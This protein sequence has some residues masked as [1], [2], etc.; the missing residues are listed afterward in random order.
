M[1]LPCSYNGLLAALSAEELDGLQPQLRQAALHQGTVLCSEGQP[2]THVYFPTTA[3]ISIACSTITGDSMDVAIIADDGLAGLTF[4]A[5]GE[6]T[7]GRVVVQRS[8]EAWRLPASV[9]RQAFAQ[10]GN[11]QLLA[12][13]YQQFLMAQMAQTALCSRLHRVDRQLCR[14]ILGSLERSG[15]ERLNATQQQVARMLGV[16][17]EAVS[18]AVGRLEQQGVLH[19]GRGRLRVLDHAALESNCCECYHVLRGQA[20]AWLPSGVARRDAVLGHQ[21]VERHPGYAQ[22]ASGERH[23]VADAL[24]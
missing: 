8:G 10:G 2:V 19:W 1:P 3:V 24:Q 21:A 22:I 17:R 5:S 23:V 6:W 7:P 16:R 15:G 20:L 4:S 14:W 9:L 11:L 18:A 12:L 13:R